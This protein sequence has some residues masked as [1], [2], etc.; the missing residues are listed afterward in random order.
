MS[1]TPRTQLIASM[2]LVSST[3]QAWGEAV[4]LRD[5]AIVDAIEDGGMTHQQVADLT[6]L[7]HSRV[8]QIVRSI[9]EMM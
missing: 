4:V 7:T 3:E 6:R 9:Q 2:Q 5:N 1:K 8:S